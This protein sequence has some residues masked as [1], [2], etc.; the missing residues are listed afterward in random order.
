[1]DVYFEAFSGLPIWRETGFYG[2]L[3]T[4]DSQEDLPCLSTLTFS[5]AST[6]GTS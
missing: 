4:T 6:D 2:P 1:M 5:S 3:P